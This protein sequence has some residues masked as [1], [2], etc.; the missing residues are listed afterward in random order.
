[1]LNQEFKMVYSYLNHIILVEQSGSHM[2]N[3]LKFQVEFE[4]EYCQKYGKLNKS[5]ILISKNRFLHMHNLVSRDK[6]FVMIVFWFL[7]VVLL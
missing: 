6:I 4:V 3:N 7:Y 2:Y 5:L 1:M